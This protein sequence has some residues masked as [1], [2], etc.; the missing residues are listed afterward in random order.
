MRPEMFEDR[1]SDARRR[2][3]SPIAP[4][5]IF[6]VVL[7]FVGV[8]FTLQQMDLIENAWDLLRF[9]PLLLVFAGANKIAWPGSS[10]SRVTGLIL[11][12]VG[13]WLLLEEL[14]VIH[15]SFWNY[16][17]LLIIFLGVRIVWQ[18]L[19]GRQDQVASDSL[20]T[21]N[22]VAVL[23]GASR[24]STSPDFRGGD[25]MAFMGG[26]NIDLTQAQIA[27]PP[28]VIDAFAFWGGV[29]IKVPLDWSV[30][31]KG[32]PLLGGYE[33]NTK[34]ATELPAEDIRQELIVKGFAIMG[35]V[36]IKN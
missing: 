6:G 13:V 15:L 19:L 30:T 5:L 35:G 18:G 10:T 8:V 34:P 1:T 23:G 4:R 17:P 7:I 31:V 3:S 21:V 25:M 33:D 26:C 29:E 12:V 36:E 14:H 32:I 20:S 2:K 24:R 11:C 9:W 28:A 22:A 27:D 16:W